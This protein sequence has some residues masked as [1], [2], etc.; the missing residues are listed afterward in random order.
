[1]MRYQV[2]L[3]PIRPIA[4]ALFYYDQRIRLEGYDIERMMAAAG[5]NPNAPTTPDAPV[6]APSTPEAQA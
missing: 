3:G 5:L 6:P 1:M 4:A 2:V